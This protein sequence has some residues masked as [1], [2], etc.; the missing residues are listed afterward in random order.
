MTSRP[1]NAE[2]ARQLR[3]LSIVQE[4]RSAP[5]TAPHEK[6]ARK[7]W[8]VAL[9][10]AITAA[11]GAGYVTTR[12]DL[13]GQTAAFLGGTTDTAQV[14]DAAAPVTVVAPA[15][16]A[17]P[18][19]QGVIGTGY[20]VAERD[21]VLGTDVGGRVA[22]IAVGVGDRFTQGQILAQLDD[23]AAQLDI[24]IAEGAVASAEQTLARLQVEREQAAVMADRVAKLAARGAVAVTEQ[25][26]AVFAL[27]LLDSDILGAGQAVATRKLEL[28]RA[29]TDL[30][31][32][33]ITAPF[34]G[35][36]VEQL[37]AAGDLVPSAMNGGDPGVGLLTL[38][39]TSSLIVEAALAETNLSQV[40]TGQLAT[41]VLDA[42]PDRRFA[43]HVQ[44]IV[45]RAQIQTGT[46]TVRLTF[47]APD[48][49]ILANMAAKVTFAPD[50]S[51]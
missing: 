47:D 37:A 35:V 43:A 12:T 41:V 6:T 5:D 9:L 26:T 3:S 19:P 38:L 23:S 7:R 51:Q 11:A 16:I 25:D 15:P 30:A 10:L 2:L 28:R 32:L 17:P 18:V 29:T 1:Q 50:A 39:D 33:T 36:V 31:R 20:V 22:R 13:L 48:T 42:W 14:A 24:A 34:D 4:S 21:I 40:R 49:A 27:R 8:P 46:V 45:P 44:G